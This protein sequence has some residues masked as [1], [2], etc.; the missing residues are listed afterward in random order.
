VRGKKIYSVA[1][2]TQGASVLIGSAM[3]NLPFYGSTL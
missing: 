3:N 2:A 1:A